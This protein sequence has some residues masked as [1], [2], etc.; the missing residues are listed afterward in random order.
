VQ[1]LKQDTKQNP[2]PP[3]TAKDLGGL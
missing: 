3:E 1:C 2:I